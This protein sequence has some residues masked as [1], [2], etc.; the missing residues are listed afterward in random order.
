[1]PWGWAQTP[2]MQWGWSGRV[3]SIS[4][5]EGHSAVCPQPLHCYQ[6]LHKTAIDLWSKQAVVDNFATVHSVQNLLTPGIAFRSCC[7]VSPAIQGCLPF[8]PGQKFLWSGVYQATKYWR[9]QNRNPSYHHCV[10]LFR[11]DLKSICK[12]FSTK[13]CVCD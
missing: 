4:E 11:L 7:E 6:P 12:Y 3:S 10:N 8:E 5:W 1:M 2:Q 13:K 9:Q